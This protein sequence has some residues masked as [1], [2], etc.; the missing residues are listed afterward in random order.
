[1]PDYAL[2]RLRLGQQLSI[3]LEDDATPSVGRVTSIS[4]SADPRN[5]V[6]SIEVTV[7][8]HGGRL[9]PGMIASHRSLALRSALYG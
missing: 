4:P 3:A 7:A 5:R 8:N 9:K 2:N 6:F 1:V